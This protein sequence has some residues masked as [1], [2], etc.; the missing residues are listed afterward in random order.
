M[1]GAVAMLRSPIRRV[2]CKA[3]LTVT[4]RPRHITSS[5]D[6]E[7]GDNAHGGG[8]TAAAGGPAAAKARR[9][10]WQPAAALHWLRGMRTMAG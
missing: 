2:Q 9:P 7:Y 8:G 6:D 1:Q 10:L 4:R 3:P 5:D